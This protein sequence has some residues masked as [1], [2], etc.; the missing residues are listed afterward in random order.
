MSFRILREKLNSFSVLSQCLISL[1]N[2]C[3]SI[4]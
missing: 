1:P 2:I 3:Q 4:A